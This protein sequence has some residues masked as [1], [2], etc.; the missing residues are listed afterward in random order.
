[1]SFL[2]SIGYVRCKFAVDSIDIAEYTLASTVLRVLKA[3]IP[4][5]FT[6]PRVSFITIS[7]VTTP[8]ICPLLFALS[9]K[10][11]LPVMDRQGGN[12]NDDS[13][14]P[15]F[16]NVLYFI[17]KFNPDGKRK[18]S[19]APPLPNMPG[20]SGSFGSGSGNG[21]PSSS[22]SSVVNRPVTQGVAR[23]LFICKP[24][25]NSHL[26]K[27]NF[28]TIVVLPKHVDQG[29]WI[30][31]NTFEFYEYIKLFYTTTLEFCVHCKTMSAGPGT[32]YYWLGT[33]RQPRP[34]PAA[35][36]I[37][38]VLTWINNRLTDETVF[39][40]RPPNSINTGGQTQ[41]IGAPHA[42]QGG[43]TWV[44][45][46]AGFPPTFFPSCQ[47][48]FKQMFR[49]FAHIYHTHFVNIVHLS[50][51]A[52]LNSFFA[53]FIMFSREFSLLDPRDL[54]PLKPLIDAFDEKGM[55]QGIKNAPA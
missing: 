13:H 46:E 25:V 7:P 51:E 40:T 50:M 9:L 23:P 28:K 38:Y 32:D 16:R 4:L 52:H 10:R 5:Q 47:A 3:P 34:L 8:F 6:C 22:S 45:K 20:S 2:N 43:Q 55:S 15:G 31:L 17:R 11:V 54:E 37:E 26:L 29:E 33:D 44:G 19:K 35:T 27:G 30:A 41:I 39:P 18:G 21:T 1:M 42:A 48:I 36:Y 24:Y 53:H 49:V 12:D 14:R